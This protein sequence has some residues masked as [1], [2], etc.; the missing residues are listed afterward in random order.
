MVFMSVSLR[1]SV[2]KSRPDFQKLLFFLP[3]FDPDDSAACDG[4]R[5]SEQ[6]GCLHRVSGD[7]PSAPP[8]HAGSSPEQRKTADVT[9][10]FLLEKPGGK[11]K[12][13]R[14]AK[15]DNAPKRGVLQTQ[16]TTCCRCCEAVVYGARA[17]CLY[18]TR[19]GFASPQARGLCYKVG[20]AV[21]TEAER[22]HKMGTKELTQ[23]NSEV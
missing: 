6:M 21:K 12:P 3:F 4:E 17:A 18:C 8:C 22:Q 2:S 13:G 14:D 16:L 5:V 9:L 19:V 23:N 20:S 15:C 11:V 7:P 10:H 1:H